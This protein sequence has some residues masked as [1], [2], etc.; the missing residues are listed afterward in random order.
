[1]RTPPTRRGNRRGSVGTVRVRGAVIQYGPLV[2]AGADLRLGVYASQRGIER[3]VARAGASMDVLL[4]AVAAAE[5]FRLADGGVVYRDRAPDGVEVANGLRARWWCASG[6][7]AADR[8]QEQRREGAR[9]CSCDDVLHVHGLVLMMLNQSPLHMR[10][11]LRQGFSLVFL[12]R[13]CSPAWRATSR[14]RRTGKRR[15]D[16]APPRRC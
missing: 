1:M 7:G 16:V 14:T 6:A 2:F 4:E 10:R 13:S 12:I 5:R 11:P 9:G 3:A 8:C 15:Q